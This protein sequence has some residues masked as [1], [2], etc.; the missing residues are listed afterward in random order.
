MS[1][2]TKTLPNGKWCSSSRWQML[3]KIV[4]LENFAHFTGKHLCWSL[5]LIK[6]IKFIENRLPT[7]VFS[8][9]FDKVLTTTFFTET[10]PVA[11]SVVNDILVI[12]QS[13]CAI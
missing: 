11:A 12:A 8:L 4:V 5:V 2:P 6:N 10:P 9:K 7:Q 1:P 13:L 3:F